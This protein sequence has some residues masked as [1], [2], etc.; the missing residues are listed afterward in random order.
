ML[1]SV[2]TKY[3]KRSMPIKNS[4]EFQLEENINQ[5]REEGLGHPV[6]QG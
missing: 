2:Y 1:S 4:Y 5:E 3:E 6:T